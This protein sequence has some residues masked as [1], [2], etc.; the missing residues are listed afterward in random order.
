MNKRK[1]ILL[2]T[3]LCMVAILAVGGTLAYFTDTDQEINVFT[4]GNVQIDLIEQQRDGKGGL[5]EFNDD[6]K[7]LPIVGSA[8]GEKDEFGLPTAKNYVDKIVTVKVL[9]K[10]E[11][12]YV[13]VLMAFPVAMDAA[14]EADMPLHWNAG[15]KYV[16]EGGKADSD[17]LN[18]DYDNWTVTGPIHKDVEID[19]YPGEYNIYSFTYE[20]PMVANEETGSA[21]V[22]GFY[23]DARVDYDED[24]GYF[25][26]IGETIYRLKTAIDENGRVYVPVF[27]QGVQAKG[28]DNATQA[29]TAA[30]LSTNPW[31]EAGWENAN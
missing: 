23:M 2:A 12:A 20:K 14:A 13:R 15:N 31:A 26:K 28:F 18:T 29:F 6:K 21:C 16:A 24:L 9:D 19:G 5:E 22:V 8:Q 25:M 7:L 3:A 17:A 1:I 4:V 27:A 11:D 30:Q 10:S